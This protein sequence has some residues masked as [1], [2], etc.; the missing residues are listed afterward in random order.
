MTI[1]PGAK[2]DVAAWTTFTHGA[3]IPD[4][5]SKAYRESYRG[6]RDDGPHQSSESASVV[7]PG[8]VGAHCRLALHR[9][10]GESAVAVY[11][12]D[13]PGGFG[14]ALQVVTDQGSML[15]DSVTVLLHRLGLGYTA[16]MTPVFEV[17]RDPTGELQRVEPKAADASPYVGE[18]WIHVQLSASVDRKVLA[19][20]E[21]LLPKV[22][23]DVQRVAKD[24]AAALGSTRC[25]S[26]VGS[27]RTSNT[28]VMIAV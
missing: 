11:P 12:A 15:M 16:I 19:E 21:R 3:D 6:P 23:A 13:D 5:V 1:D 14:P 7:T 25:S 26:P 20:V 8:V 18:A 2:E 28:G 9:P 22:L 17:R 27:R 24:A 10:A 4:W